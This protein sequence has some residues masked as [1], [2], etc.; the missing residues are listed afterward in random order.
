MR[1]PDRRN[2]WSAW[3]LPPQPDKAPASLG[4]WVVHCPRAHAF[5]SFWTV[6]L[7]HLRPLEGAPPPS[8]QYPGAGY[9]LLTIALDPELDPDVNGGPLRCL[10]PVDV[11]EQFHGCTDEEAAQLLDLFIRSIVDGHLSPDS[12]CRA[13]WKRSIWA[14]LEH[15]TTGHP[16][17]SA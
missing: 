14:T 12:D 1:S 3:R 6:Q 7:V 11:C 8:L 13:Q 5:W 16:V 9:E 2:V 17:A 15:I 10:T 4:A